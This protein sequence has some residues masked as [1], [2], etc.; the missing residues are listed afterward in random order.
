MGANWLAEANATGQT[1]GS[2]PAGYY[3]GN[4]GFFFNI[5]FYIP[6]MGGWSPDGYGTVAIA[7]GFSRVDYSLD[8]E[9]DYVQE[10]VLP[11]YFSAGVDVATIKVAGYEGEL[12]ATQIAN[13][14]DA[15][16]A[17]EEPNAVSVSTEDFQLDEEENVLI[18]ATGLTFEKS[19]TYTV[20]AVAFD[21]TGKAQ[22]STSA[23]HSY[24]SGED[25]EE[26]AVDFSVGAEATPSRFEG[27][28][29]KTS[30]AFYIVGKDVTEA[31][32]GIIEA[33]K[34][35]ADVET[36]QAAVKSNSNL[37]LSEAAIAAVNGEGGYYDIASGLDPSTEYVV[38]VWANNGNEE[39]FKTAR[40]TTDGLPNEIV[41]E[42]CICPCVQR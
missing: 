22:G 1:D 20:V 31:H 16:A 3:D 24:V 8:M 39:A 17:G 38:I 23:V 4:G 25:A 37:A 28:D 35:D 6:G 36:Y 19:G 14:A 5:Y 27:Y 33:A 42:D 2:Y 29:A 41:A 11:V 12:T 7:D 13:K 32:V 30:F 40:F 15:I 26:Y 10:G 34:Y 18:G 21:A 9:L